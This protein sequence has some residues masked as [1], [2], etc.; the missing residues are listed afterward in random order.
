MHYP[1]TEQGQ[2]ELKNITASVH[3]DFVK[4]YIQHLSCP[5]EQKIRLMKALLSDKK[6][7]M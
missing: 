2:N 5:K 4:N 3:A 1:Q 7:D 6:R